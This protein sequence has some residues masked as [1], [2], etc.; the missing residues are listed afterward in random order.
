VKN[1]HHERALENGTQVEELNL[2]RQKIGS[3]VPLFEFDP[4]KQPLAIYPTVV[5]DIGKYICLSN[6]LHSVLRAAIA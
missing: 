5:Q 6:D 2:K 1:L 4:N 3:Y